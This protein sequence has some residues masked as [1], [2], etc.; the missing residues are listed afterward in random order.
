MIVADAGFLQEAT[1]GFPPKMGSQSMTVYLS[2]HASQHVEQLRNLKTQHLHLVLGLSQHAHVSELDHDPSLTGRWGSSEGGFFETVQ[3]KLQEWLGCPV[4]V[5][6]EPQLLLIWSCSFLTLKSDS[7]RMTGYR[8]NS[9]LD[10]LNV[11]EEIYSLG[12]QSEEMGKFLSS[13]A[14][15]SS[16]RANASTPA[17]L[18][19]VDRNLDLVGPSMH[20]ESIL[21]PLFTKEHLPTVDL[22][23]T[24]IEPELD[25][26][27][28]N[29]LQLLMDNQKQS[30]LI[31]RK[32]LLD[33]LG[34]YQSVPKVL[35]RPN[36]EQLKELVQLIPLEAY[37]ENPLLVWI[38]GIVNQLNQQ[39]PDLVSIEQTMIKSLSFSGDVMT[40]ISQ[41]CDLLKKIAQEKQDPQSQ[42]PITTKD[43]LH[44]AILLY[45]LLPKTL[46]IYPEQETILKQAFLKAMMAANPKANPRQVQMWIQSTFQQLQ[47]VSEKRNHLSQLADVLDFGSEH[48][49][50]PLIVRIGMQ[51]LSG[52]PTDLRH[53]KMGS[54]FFF[55][56]PK[57]QSI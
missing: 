15:M 12:P 57:P 47:S 1:L 56:P 10:H 39:R 26:Q 34:Q 40:P 44:L 17:H 25:S 51:V 3:R 28:K 49:Y 13:I 53:H 41:L 23:F 55:S 29:L 24:T 43:V 6:Y 50:V 42:F 4:T 33:I 36:P 19:L 18:I 45:S 5:T 9:I 54:L 11:K 46:S 2:T 20:T 21:E 27:S 16:R 7:F 8:I 38:T 35:G 37:A 48:P 22:G 52:N 31:L 30:L 14:S 32:H